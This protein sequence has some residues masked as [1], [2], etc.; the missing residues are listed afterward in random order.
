MKLGDDPLYRPGLPKQFATVPDGNEF[1]IG[2]SSV[3]H[4][5]I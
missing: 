2:L 5:E 3:S 4:I 1:N